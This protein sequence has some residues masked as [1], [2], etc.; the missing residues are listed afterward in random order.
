MEFNRKNMRSLA[1]LIAFGILLL[2][3]LQN[4]RAVSAIVRR[5]FGLLAPFLLGGC[6]AFILNV[7]MAF[8]ERTLLHR[9]FRARRTVSIALSLLLVIGLLAFAS[10]MV[11]PQLG[12]SLQSIGAAFPRFFKEMQ[13]SVAALEDKIPLLADWLTGAFGGWDSIDWP[14]LGQTV[15]TFLSG[16]GDLI[17]STLGVA[18]SVVSGFVNFF[19]GLFFAIY[20]LAQKER[21]GRQVKKLLYATL[22][23]S[24]ADSFLAVCTLA[25]QTFS[26]FITGQ[27]AEACILGLM[28]FVSMSLLHFPYA[29]LI[30]VLIG[31]TA[32]VPIFGTF[33][34]CAFGAFFIL[35]ENPMQA[36][37]FIILFL[38]LQQ[39]EGNL[40]YPHV[41]GGS[42]GL[43]SIWVLV[44]VSV[45]GASMGVVGM[46]IFIPIFSVLYA[47][48][49][50]FTNRRLAA[51]GVPPEK[52]GDRPV[53]P[54]K[55]PPKNGAS[56]PTQKK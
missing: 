55:A 32:L 15:W 27:C 6:I 53:K 26:N 20:V 2:T 33:V 46:L 4:F 45:G 5:F 29:A 41:V 40:I 30:S 12:R 37:W 52:W 10:G 56:R 31:I 49:R 42:V 25:Q 51:R 14:K 23:I 8:F 13:S 44:A 50:G 1:L 24:Q 54:A 11:I 28:F 43:P 48:L 36:L 3:G 22:S 19:L 17:G 39:I 7:P 16:T 38:V 35:I 34:G 21:L 47:L 9:K 18:S